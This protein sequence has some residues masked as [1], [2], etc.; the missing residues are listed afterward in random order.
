METDNVG[1]IP[2]LNF[3][4]REALDFFLSGLNAAMRRCGVEELTAVEMSC[5]KNRDGG[6]IIIRMKNGDGEIRTVSSESFGRSV[7][8]RREEAIR[9]VE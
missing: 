5:I 8:Q 7:F 6:T 4:G 1:Y 9:A 2:Y 3:N